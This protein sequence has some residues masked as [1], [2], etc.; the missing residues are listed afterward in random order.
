MKLTAKHSC[1][2]RI[3]VYILNNLLFHFPFIFKRLQCVWPMTLRVRKYLIPNV[4]FILPVI[5]IITQYD[6]C[7]FTFYL[8]FCIVKL[9]YFKIFTFDFH[10]NL[11]SLISTFYQDRHRSSSLHRHSKFWIIIIWREPISHQIYW[12]PNY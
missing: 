1:V 4:D 8:S 12:I 3:C 10:P 11:S 6:W 5:I 9:F 2:H 7:I